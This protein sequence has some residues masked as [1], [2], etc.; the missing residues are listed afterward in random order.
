MPAVP[1]KAP[2]DPARFAFPVN[3]LHIWPRGSFMMIGLPNLDG[4]ITLTLFM[5]YVCDGHGFD[6]LK[7]DDQIRSFMTTHFPDAVPHMGDYLADWHRNLVG[8]LG[9]V[10]TSAYHAGDSV[11]LMGD[12]AHATVPFYGQGMNAGF[13]D[14][15]VFVELLGQY[16]FSTQRAQLLEAYSARQVPAGH[17]VVQL[18][19]NN[20]L[21]MRAH[22]A[23]RL[24]LLQKTVENML[25]RMLGDRWIPQYKM[26]A[27]TT[28][29]YNEV[30]RRD[31]RQQVILRRATRLI[32][33]GVVAGLGY[34]AYRILAPRL[35]VRLPKLSLTW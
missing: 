30:I 18:S 21:E 13:Q 31:A 19:L 7:T 28:I 32:L 2:D 16:S 8:S 23:S 20:Y 5:P 35:N 34:A 25:H 26:V 24:F 1:G 11:L 33:V 27:F 4:S 17:G 10:H 29:P 12:A 14:V 22:T 6:E 9:M 3:Y 15:S